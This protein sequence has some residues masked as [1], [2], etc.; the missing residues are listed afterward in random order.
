MFKKKRLV[1][2]AFL[3]AAV[4]VGW[5]YGW[6]YAAVA[7]GLLVVA[8][9]ALALVQYGRAH[10]GFKQ[11][12][13]LA[14]DY[15][16]DALVARAKAQTPDASAFTFVALGDTRNKKR[17]TSMVYKQAATEKPALV[18]HTG[19]IVRHGTAKEYL[20]NHIA[21]LRH[22]DPAPMLCVPGNHE[23][24]ARRD[25]GAFKL[26]YGDDK[27][28]FD[29]GPCRFVGFNNSRKVRVSEKD[30]AFVERALAESDAPHRFVFMHI[31]PVFFEDT[32]STERRRR[33]F[34]ENAD[35]L[36]ALFQKHKVN[37]V[38]MAH[39]HGYASHEFDGVR[40]TLTA[41]GGAPLSKH[42]APEARCYN[43]VVLHVTPGGVRREVMRKY[44]D[45]EWQRSDS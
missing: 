20:D 15:Q 33:G 38:F 42:M 1:L 39:I 8:L 35:R 43:Y 31:P 7:V 18:F 11:L 36:H 24:G 29:F 10:A 34:K 26:L 25:F 16:V 27:F 17:I 28:A 21:L 45:A 12:T 6:L 23:R 3:A 19:D 40:Y 44:P 5:A 9:G 2:W 4:Y 13:A 22:T 14:P 41:G 30:L 37:E 32:F